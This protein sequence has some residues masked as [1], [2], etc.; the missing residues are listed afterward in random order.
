M[1]WSSQALKFTM[2]V[3]ILGQTAV[4]TDALKPL[5][6]NWGTV[7][8]LVV[9]I[10]LIV[11][12]RPGEVIPAAWV[13]LVHGSSVVLYLA[14]SLATV[15]TMAIRGSIPSDAPMGLL[16]I[17]AGEAIAPNAKNAR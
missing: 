5:L 6:G 10:A 17:N 16:S 7:G 14:L 3:G 9:P 1:N 15:T 4:L 8:L 11:M 12:V 13:K 2:G